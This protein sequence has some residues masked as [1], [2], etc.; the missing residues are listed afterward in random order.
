MQTKLTVRVDDQ[1]IQSA[2]RYASKRGIS[3]SRLIENYL[4]S[5][6]VEQD[7]QL[8]QTPIL[9]RLSG[10]LPEDASIEDQRKRWDEKY[11]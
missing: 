11:G 7:E 9:Q 6:A 8:V 5:L 1:L 2:K 3:L 10:I 4:S